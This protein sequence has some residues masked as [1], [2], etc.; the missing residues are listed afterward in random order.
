MSP[1]A[2]YPNEKKGLEKPS[3]VQKVLLTVPSNELISSRKICIAFS[4]FYAP[5]EESYFNAILYGGLQT[6][7]ENMWEIVVLIINSSILA[8]S[9]GGAVLKVGGRG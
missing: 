9:M 5:K 1:A 2:K 4:A 8:I 6:T 3:K 7:I